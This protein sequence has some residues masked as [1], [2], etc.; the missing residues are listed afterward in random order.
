MRQLA[1][2]IIWLVCLLP[3]LAV[4]NGKDV[5]SG[6]M[7]GFTT[8][9]WEELRM[10]SLLPLYTE[11]IPLAT[12]YRQYNYSVEF[13]YPEYGNLTKEEEKVAQRYA[14]HIGERILPDVHIGVQRGEGMLD[15]SF[16][17][18]VK[19]GNHIKKLLSCRIMITPHAKARKVSAKGTKRY[20]SHSVLSSGKWVKIGITEDGIYSLTR[21]KLKKMGFANPDKVRLFGYGGHLQSEKI[22]PD[23]DYDDLQEVPL[24][25]Q[26]DNNWLFWGNGLV[27]WEG[28]ERIRNNY[29]NEAYYFLTEGDSPLKADTL[30][31]PTGAV[32]NHYTTVPAHTLYEKDEFAW[33]STGRNLYDKYNYANGNSCTYTL[34]SVATSGNEKLTVAFTAASKANVQLQPSVNGTQLSPAMTLY[35]IGSYT[36]AYD[37]TRTYDISKMKGT[38]ENTWK[39]KLVTTS[40]QD[41]RLDYLALHYDRKIIPGNDGYVLFSQTGKGVSQFDITWPDDHLK[42]MRLGKPGDPDAWVKTTKVDD[43]TRKMVV[44][45]ATRRYV[46]FVDTYTFPEPDYVGVVENQD[47]HAMDSIDMVILIPSSGKLEGQAQRLAD[48]HAEYD[49]LRVQVVR[50]DQAYNEF[51]SGTPDATAYRR[52]MKML[53]DK[54]S[55]KTCAPKYLLLMGD[56]AWDN[57]M[58]SAAWHNYNPDDYLLCYESDNS[59]S[60][61]KSYV[62]E[63]YFGMLDDGEGSN[64]LKDKPDLGIGRFPVTSQSEAKVMVDK[65]IAYLTCQ[66]VGDWKNLVCF[67]GDDGDNNE[68]MK[69][70]DDVALR[71]ANQNPEVEIRKVMWDAYTRVSTAKNNTYPE[72]TTLL[73]KLMDEG[74]LV[75]NYTGHATTYTLSHEFVLNL[76]DFA[77]AKGDALPLWVTAACDV[78]PFDGQSENIGETAVLN[79]QGGAVA[80]YGT[81]RTVY[82]NQNL[83]MNRYFMKYLFSDDASGQRNRVGDAVR[84]AKNAI[85]NGNAEYTQLENKLQ[86]ALLGDPALTIAPPQTHVLLDEINDVSLSGN[87]SV[88]LKAGSRV[89]M[90]GHVEDVKGGTDA[91]FQGVLSLRLFDSETLVTCQNNAGADKAFVFDNYSNILYT[92]QDSVRNGKF[93]LSF[94]IPVDINYTDEAGR[95]IFYAYDSNQKKEANGYSESF[96]LGGVSE[97]LASDTIGPKI[98][99]FLNDENFQDGDVVNSC[100]FFIAGLWDE[101]GL[102]VSGNGLGHDLTLCIDGRADYTFNL[103]DRY[104][105][106]FGDNTRGVVSYSIPELENGPH[107]LEFSA[108]DVLN[109]LSTSSLSFVVDSSLKPELLQISASPSPALTS[110]NFI[111]SYNRPG[112]ECTIRVDV[113]DFMGRNLWTRTEVGSSDAGCCM[114]PWNLC[115]SSGGKLGSGVYLY[116]CTLQCGTSK[117]VSKAQKIIVK[118]NK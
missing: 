83:S 23:A 54:A 72:V 11:V 3:S 102:N 113:Y 38:D 84:L 44:D 35:P 32:V 49:G 78:M 40:G 15:L 17:P 90:K 39:V 48:A 18:L 67:M 111:I 30:P 47:L 75:M 97:E 55:D 63:D 109:N 91:T 61:T 71:V 86:Y 13:E 43:T 81:T 99:A 19:Q 34:S 94:T 82:A 79:D 10:D 93:E 118:N 103:N 1:L 64:L 65:T 42:V 116:R 76:E 41:A 70:A 8:L 29:A 4:G 46:A 112:A 31:T 53:Y 110:T 24:Y 59:L 21:N 117:E 73:K 5:G 114:I 115:T 36:Y 66:H 26:G 77:E 37:D 22:D 14:E 33:H 98:M 104:E 16:V 105:G 107:T 7:N 92:A 108:W 58:L 101:S 50:A 27:Y 95:A 87:N 68:H 100:P 12:D 20:T 28:N 60:D 51:S 56:A 9:D 80:F 74:A 57:R 96:I 6:K 89:T 88:Q 69:Y 52:M 85:I 106:A 25:K 62:M 2:Y 45:D